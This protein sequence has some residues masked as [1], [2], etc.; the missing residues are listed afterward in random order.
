MNITLNHRPTNT[1]SGLT[2]ASFLYNQSDRDAGNQW[3][4]L[5]RDKDIDIPLLPND[6]LI[7]HGGENIFA[8]DTNFDIGENPNLRKPVCFRFNDKSMEADKAKLTGHE[9]RK[10]DT[11]LESSKLFADLSGQAD[12]MIQDDWM[13]V[14]QEKDGY[15]TIPAGDGETID[16]EECARAE[17]RPPKGQKCYRIKID[18]GKYKVDQPSLTGQ[19]ILGLVQKNYRE[20]TLNQKL[21][22]GR[23]KPIEAEQMVDFSQPGVER[24]E[25]VKKQAQ[26]GTCV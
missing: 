18:G 15:F 12:A 11:K 23:R 6:Y 2:R 1:K 21:H 10:L 13:L 19:E 26:Q 14:V 9:L 4:Y 17:R 7:I 22:G 24:F 20:W 5:D 25:T 16:I 3:L 8:D